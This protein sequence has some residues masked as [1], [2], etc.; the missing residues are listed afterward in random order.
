[1]ASR[2]FPPPRFGEELDFMANLITDEL[3]ALAKI[4][5]EWIEPAPGIP[6]VYLFGSRVR[7]DH[8]PDS[9]VDVRLY[10]QEWNVCENTRQWREKQNATDFANLKALLPGPLALHR[11]MQD[12]ADESIRAGVKDPVLKVGRVICVCTRR[13]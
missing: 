1:M 5:A 6:A 11:E 7:G 12:A 8:C 10:L 9:D 4:L 13:R 2:R 3:R